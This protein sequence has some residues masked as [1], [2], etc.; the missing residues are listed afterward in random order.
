[1]LDVALVVPPWKNWI[2]FSVLTTLLICARCNHYRHV[3]IWNFCSHS[4]NLKFSL[5][6]S[7][8][9]PDGTHYC[10]VFYLSLLHCTCV[11]NFTTSEVPK[12]KC[13]ENYALVWK[14]MRASALWCCSILYV[15][16]YVS[17]NLRTGI[18]IT[19][20]LHL[21]IP[22]NYFVYRNAFINKA[23]KYKTH[24]L[25]CRSPC[26]ISYSPIPKRRPDNVGCGRSEERHLVA[27]TYVGRPAWIF[28]PPNHMHSPYWRRHCASRGGKSKQITVIVVKIDKIKCIKFNKVNWW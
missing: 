20:L 19:F 24:I 7:A 23:F 25:I 1:M 13:F 6:V 27:V 10:I 8:I 28:G 2:V 5:S 3:K 16:N 11:Q 14:A 26:A 18:L 4:E 22:P 17:C 15:C 21:Y 9:G 12:S